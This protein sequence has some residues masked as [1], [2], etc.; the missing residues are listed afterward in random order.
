MMT[1]TTISTQALTPMRK[2]ETDREGG[3][4]EMEGGGAGVWDRGERER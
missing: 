3:A 2:S 1:M 4:R